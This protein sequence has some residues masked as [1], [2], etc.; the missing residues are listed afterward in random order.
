MVLTLEQP[1][2]TTKEGVC[3]PT[4]KQ[5]VVH[6]TAVIYNFSGH[7]IP[8]SVFL[9]LRKKGHR[10]FVI[11]SAAVHVDLSN[12]LGQQIEAVLDR[13][14]SVRNNQEELPQE[15]VG[16][17]YYLGCGHSTANLL[18][19]TALS[20][21]LGTPPHLLIT[22]NNDI[23]WNEYEFKQTL[24]MKGWEGRWRSIMRERYTLLHKEILFSQPVVTKDC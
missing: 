10:K 24:V 3:S 8:Q 11:F 9:P 6:E 22:G 14:L 15:V 2:T 16:E 23:R 17:R 4:K 7:K 1:L 21:I 20:S 19:F 5:K 12:D 13:M 18:V